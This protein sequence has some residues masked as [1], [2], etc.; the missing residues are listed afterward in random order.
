MRKKQ[1]ERSMDLQGVGC[2]E[3][4]IARDWGEDDETMDFASFPSSHMYT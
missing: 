4:H 3:A 1:R 2:Y